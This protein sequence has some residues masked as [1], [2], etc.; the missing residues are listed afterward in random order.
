MKT[1]R[2]PMNYNGKKFRPIQN[3]ENGETSEDT[4]FE[5]TQNGNIL[6]SPEMDQKESQF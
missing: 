2:S 6:T 3:I 5:Y 1:T 4:I